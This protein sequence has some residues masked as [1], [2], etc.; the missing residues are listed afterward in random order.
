MVGG[1]LQPIVM[2]VKAP[3]N[4]NPNFHNGYNCTTFSWKN[5]SLWQKFWDMIRGKDVSKEVKFNKNNRVQV[6]VF[7]VNY[8]FY[9]SSGIKVKMQKRKKFLGITYWKGKKADKIAIGFNMLSGEMKFTNPRSFSTITPTN[10]TGWG[11]FKLTINKINHNYILGVYNKFE[12]IKDWVDDIY[13]LM[14][15]INIPYPGGSLTELDLLN[16]LYSIPAEQVFSQLK[17]LTGKILYSPIQKKI[18]PKDPRMSYFVWGSANHTYNKDKSYIIGVQEYTNISSKTVRFDRSFG[19]NISNGGVRG[20]VPSEFKIKDLDMFGACYY[21]K[22]WKG[23]RF[24][25]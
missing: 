18:Q 1:A 25:K 4:Y 5:N 21:D 16:K 15:E 17:S 3:E 8:Q 12:I 6:E 11:A 20:F 22:Q 23:V 2:Q 13:F 14:P 19:I 9:A 10:S 24:V 7:N